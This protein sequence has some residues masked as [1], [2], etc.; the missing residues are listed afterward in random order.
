MPSTGRRT[1]AKGVAQMKLG[2]QIPYFTYPGGPAALGATF[3]RIVQEAEAAG[4]ASLWVMDHYFQLDGWGS[5]DLAMLECYTTLG[6]AAAVTRRV[7]LG[8]LVA[9]I[10]YRRPALLVKT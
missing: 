8:P 5:P 3:A 4:F 1:V 7:Q 10:S 6:Y 9:G 2:L